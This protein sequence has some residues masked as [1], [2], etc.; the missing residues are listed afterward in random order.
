MLV[1]SETLE[2][3]RPFTRSRDA[4]AEARAAA[5][6]RALLSALKDAAG[7]AWAGA[8]L[9]G[10]LGRGEGATLVGRDGSGHP[11]DPFEILAVLDAPVR[12]VP[13][14]SRRLA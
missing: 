7:D 9:G 11:A 3:A 8:A 6:L 4:G 2:A 10:A 5:G 1:P 12:D 14:I 13:A